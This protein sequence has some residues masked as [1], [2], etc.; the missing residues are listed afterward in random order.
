M[1]NEDEDHLT[2][3]Q[4]KIHAIVRDMRDMR[5]VHKTKIPQEFALANEVEKEPSWS[6][7]HGDSGPPNSRTSFVDL[8]DGAMILAKFAP[9]DVLDGRNDANLVLHVDLVDQSGSPQNLYELE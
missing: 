2:I 8:P 5:N 3:E 1:P 4:E 9:Y 7:I 6:L